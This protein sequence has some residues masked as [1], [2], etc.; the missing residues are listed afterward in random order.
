MLNH[1]KKL[2]KRSP[3]IV[4]LYAG[5]R[6][7]IWHRKSA[8]YRRI[9][10]PW[11]LKRIPQS[12]K[13][14]DVGGVGEDSIQ[15]LTAE[16][17]RRGHLVTEVDFKRTTFKYSNFTFIE[18]NIL[19]VD[20]PSSA[21]DIVLA[22]HVLQHI[23]RKWRN[24]SKILDNQGDFKFA[25]K[26]YNWLKPG[27]VAFVETTIAS[28]SQELVWDE[29]TAWRIYT[30]ELLKEIFADFEVAE[31][32]IYDGALDSRKRVEDAKAIVLMLRKPDV[33]K[34]IAPDYLEL[35]QERKLM[36][37]G[38]MLSIVQWKEQ[39]WAYLGMVQFQG[40]YLWRGHDIYSLEPYSEK[41]VI[42][43]RRT[44]S[45]IIA[46]GKVNLF[47]AK[48]GGKEK[49]DIF[50]YQKILRY[51][52]VDGIHFRE[53]EKITDGSAPFIF[54]H[55]KS[56]YL[57]FHRRT[58]ELHEILVRSGGTLEEL[59]GSQEIQLATRME[60]FSVPSMAYFHGKFWLTC[61]EL[62][63]KEWITVI[64]KGDNPTGPFIQ[65]SQVLLRAPCAYQHIFGDRYILTYSK[66]LSG[67]I[68]NI[69]VKEG[70]L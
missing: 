36:S 21:F 28:E 59:K 17:L 25:K 2:V 45:A 48:K 62:V 15:D 9:S 47:C 43:N 11:I 58:D 66:Q 49:G 61:E 30:I 50:R 33:K 69:R 65:L 14:L 46:D 20:F 6:T 32:L 29:D 13:I 31:Q 5:M 35:S 1:I 12:A 54:R 26:I 52:S 24:L 8:K 38:H 44:A 23:G 27:G 40:I 42:K 19:N 7:R 57:Y 67:V 16:L 53:I 18:D 4:K 55:G 51:D 64:F 41:P 22:I 56:Y 68:W 37:P 63:E 70:R 34:Q 10:S 60:S 39:F 3:T